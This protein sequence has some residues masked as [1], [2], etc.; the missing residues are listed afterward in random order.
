MEAQNSAMTNSGHYC[1]HNVTVESEEL[2]RRFPDK[3]THAEQ[4]GLP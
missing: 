1:T 4:L 2:E 3:P